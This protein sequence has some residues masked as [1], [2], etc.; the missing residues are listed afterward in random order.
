MIPLSTL[1]NIESRIIPLVGVYFLF[2][3]VNVGISLD[4]KYKSIKTRRELNS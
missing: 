1:A 4:T 3:R 2:E